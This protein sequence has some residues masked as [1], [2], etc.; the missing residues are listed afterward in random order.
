MEY[1]EKEIERQACEYAKYKQR[2]D[3]LRKE[4]EEQLIRERVKRNQERAEL[5]KKK[6]LEIQSAQVYK[7]DEYSRLKDMWYVDA[8]S[9]KILI[10]AQ[11]AKIKY[12]HCF[13][14]KRNTLKRK[15]RL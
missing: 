13:P 6:I 14:G 2:V 10:L 11:K 8:S 9:T 15:K 3:R 12:I 1:H 4:K 5:A 7:A